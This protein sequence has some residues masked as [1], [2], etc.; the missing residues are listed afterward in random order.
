MKIS[1]NQLESH[2]KKPLLPCYL[3]T[4]DEFLLVQLQVG[5]VSELA[6]DAEGPVQILID[7]AAMNPKQP[8]FPKC[9][10]SHRLQPDEPH[11]GAPDFLC[12]WCAT[13]RGRG[14]A[15]PLSH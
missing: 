7:A 2:L 1:A 5:D 15:F 13:K 9:F 11:F 12:P 14:L 8:P 4:G 10:H 3:V 6:V